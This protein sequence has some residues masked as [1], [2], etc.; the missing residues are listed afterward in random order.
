MSGRKSRKKKEPGINRSTLWLMGIVLLALGLLG[1]GIIQTRV[2]GVGSGSNEDLLA[3][4]NMSGGMTAGG[5]ALVLEAL[6]VCA[7]PVFAVLTV[8]GFQKTGHFR[9]Y[10]LRVLGLAFLCE[11]PYNFAVSARV[12]DP[13]SKNP[14]FSLVLALIVLYFY[15]QYQGF[16]AAKILIKIVVAAAALFWAMAFQ[17]RFGAIMVIVVTVLWTFRERSSLRS[18]LGAAV[19]VCCCVTNPLYMFAPFGFLAAH[20]YNEEKGMIGRGM[21]YAAY[22][23]LLMMVSAAGYLMF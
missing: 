8:D 10:M 23:V 20:L 5:V 4:L 15:R 9:N 17:V 13:T 6:E 22:P 21:Q 1:R 19:C 18:M 2:L 11:L 3:A 12:W 14:V 16:G 7:V